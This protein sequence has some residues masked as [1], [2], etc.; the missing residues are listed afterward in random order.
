MC[1]SMFQLEHENSSD[2]TEELNNT[3]TKEVGEDESAAEAK[4]NYNTAGNVEALVVYESIEAENTG[5]LAEQ[6][7]EAIET[8]AIVHA[9]AQFNIPPIVNIA[10]D[11]L[12]SLQK[13]IHGE[14]R[15]PMMLLLRM[16][17]KMT[18]HKDA[19]KN[20]ELGLFKLRKKMLRRINGL[21]L[22]TVKLKVYVRMGLMRDN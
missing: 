2:G 21:L 16:R 20:D 8:T 9:M 7:K 10:Q 22:L 15:K 1:S 18:L 11:D 13:F 17:R 5:A 19:K 14:T 3:E 6:E 4:E 12:N